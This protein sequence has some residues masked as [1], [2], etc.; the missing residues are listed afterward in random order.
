[1]TQPMLEGFKVI[2][3]TH[4]VAGPHA[5]KILAEHGAEVIKIEPLGGELARLLPMQREGRSAYF[6]QHNVGKK[7]MALDISTKEGQ[8]ICHELIKTA[9]VVVENFSPGVM[10]QHNLD[11]KTLKKI[12]PDL[13]M[14]SISCF[15]QTGPLSHLP[16]YD[17]IGQSYAGIIDL[18]GEPGQ[19]PVFGDIAFGDVSTGAHAFGAIVTALLHKTRGGKGQHI[20]ISLME[21]LFSY[22]EMGVQLYDTTGG[23]MLVQRSGSYHGMLAPVGIYQCKDK[24]LFILGVNHQWEGLSKA[25]GR[26]DM[27]ADPRFSDL[28][29]MGQHK[30]EINAAIEA[31]LDSVGDI[32]RALELLREN[33]VPCAPILT[34]AEVMDHPHTKERGTVRTVSDPIFGDI[35]IPRTPLRFSEFPDTPNLQAGTLGQY[36]HEILRDQLG[37]S[38]QQIA[39]LETDGVIASKNI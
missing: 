33:R 18:L 38:E 37:Y 1:M 28:T 2:D 10:K 15:G 21:V 27:F 6:I 25:M 3:F 23:Q 26:E 32:D 5:T 13:I 29:T 9:D 34:L 11:W 20:D 36:N 14:C 12:N 4:V 39:R 7:T 24:Y 22:H 30:D 19:K 8:D 17:W 31:W 35:R 16:G